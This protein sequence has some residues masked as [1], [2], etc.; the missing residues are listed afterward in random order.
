MSFAVIIESDIT[1]FEKGLADATG[2]AEGFAES[3]YVA[4][5]GGDAEPWNETLSTATDDGNAWA[6]TTFSSDLDADPQPWNDVLAAAMT[7]GGNWESEVFVTNLDGN[8]DFFDA[9]VAEVDG[10]TMGTAYIE[11]DAVDSN[12]DLAGSGGGGGNQLGGTVRSQDVSSVAKV[13]QTAA[14]GRTVLVGEAGPE[15]AF[16]P[17]GTQ[18]MPSTPSRSRMAADGNGGGMRFY[19]PVHIHAASP[20]IAREIERQMT[21]RAM[22]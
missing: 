9:V 19:G 2:Q 6:E 12:G 3:S 10:K 17:F 4:E 22:R 5:I 11:L 21:T 18:V 14:N 20:D 13:Y 7:E 15:L 8:R 16:L 1:E